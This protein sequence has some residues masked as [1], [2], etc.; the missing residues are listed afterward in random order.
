MGGH[1][2]PAIEGRA[3]ELLV[4][5]AHQMQIQRWLRRRLIVEGRPLEAEKFTLAAYTHNRLFNVNHRSSLTNRSG[6]LFFSATFFQP[7]KFHLEPPDLF[8]KFCL[9]C[10]L[11]PLLAL[12]IAGE[13]A[14]PA[15]Q[16]LPFPGP[17]Q[18]GMNLVFT[19]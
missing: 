8:I 11:I 19:R 3:Q 5:Q 6:Q 13:D 14:G 7:L 2:G 18:V 10:L 9:L 1:L 12:A 17:Y 16:Q 15:F 4:N